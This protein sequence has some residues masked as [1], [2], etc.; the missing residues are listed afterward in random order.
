MISIELI[1]N[2]V[3]IPVNLKYFVILPI[4]LF[5]NFVVEESFWKV[6]K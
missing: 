5:E 3:F 2:A 1:T 4:H 6:A